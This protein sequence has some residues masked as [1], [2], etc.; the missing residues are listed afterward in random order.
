[1]ATYFLFGKYTQNSLKDASGKRTDKA[2]KL[3]KECGG[4]LLDAYALLGEKDLVLITE[5][6]STKEAAQASIAL[7][8]L[9]GIG[10][11]TSEAIPVNE[12]TS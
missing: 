11:A 6:S 5:F 8:K 10:F 9:T 2:R 7:T 1:M 12:F 3:I 4:K